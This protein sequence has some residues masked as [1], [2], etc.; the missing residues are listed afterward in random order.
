MPQARPS[1]WWTAREANERVL[2]MHEA[3]DRVVGMDEAAVLGMHEADDT[4]LGKQVADGV[5][6]WVDMLGDSGR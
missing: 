6:P 3:A 5:M 2:G 1:Q 4:L